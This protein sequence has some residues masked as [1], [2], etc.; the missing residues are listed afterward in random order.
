MKDV[1][2]QIQQSTVQNQRKESKIKNLI[3]NVKTKAKSIIQS[4]KRQNNKMIVIGNSNRQT[5]QG[6]ENKHIKRPKELK[7]ET[8][9]I[10]CSV[11][12]PRPQYTTDSDSE[13]IN[14]GIAKHTFRVIQNPIPTKKDTSKYTEKHREKSKHED[15]KS[16]LKATDTKAEAPRMYVQ[17]SGS[18][19]DLIP[20]EKP[21]NSLDQQ[22]RKNDAKEVAVAPPSVAYASVIQE[23]SKTLTTKEEDLESISE[24]QSDMNF[25]TD[26]N[27]LNAIEEDEVYNIKPD[28]NMGIK[29]SLQAKGVLKSITTAPQFQKKKVIF[30]LESEESEISNIL[31][32]LPPAVQENTFLAKA[33]EYSTNFNVK[34]AV[35]RQAAG[36]ST[37]SIGSSVF[38]GSKT[39]LVEILKNSTVKK[40]SDSSDWELSDILK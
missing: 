35:V 33:T 18:S 17:D 38:D 2:Q 16:N 23:F 32:Q 36:G 20:L 1:N 34:N 4:E 9:S 40:G 5:N 13:N 27:E 26:Q 7:Q 21:K 14:K 24:I 3:G 22:L 37:T 10:G 28:N 39:N 31:H 19:D 25:T 30:D 29:S 15:M 12:T 6:E 11:P 8:K